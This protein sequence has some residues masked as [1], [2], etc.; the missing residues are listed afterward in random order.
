MGDSFVISWGFGSVRV[1]RRAERRGEMEMGE[2]GQGGEG[3]RQRTI[4]PLKHSLYSA[5]ASGAGHFDV[6]LVMVGGC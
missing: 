6:E 5:R 3:Q 4:H 2:V 1:A